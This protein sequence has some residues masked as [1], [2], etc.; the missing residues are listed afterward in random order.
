MTKSFCPCQ[1][2][3]VRLDNLHLEVVLASPRTSNPFLSRFKA[4]VQAASSS[5]DSLRRTTSHSQLVDKKFNSFSAKGFSE[6]VRQL[7]LRIDK[8]KLYYIP[9]FKLDAL[10]NGKSDVN[11]FLIENGNIVDKQS[12]SSFVI[13]AHWNFIESKAIVGKL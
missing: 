6:D 12:N 5:L 9:V 4:D 2:S 8:V 7:I 1:Q 13:T 3:V 11:M 10:R